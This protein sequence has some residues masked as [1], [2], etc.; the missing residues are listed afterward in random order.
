M[1]YVPNQALRIEVK[2]LVQ[3]HLSFKYVLDILQNG[4]MLYLKVRVKCP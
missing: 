3:I 2:S 1:F 4:G